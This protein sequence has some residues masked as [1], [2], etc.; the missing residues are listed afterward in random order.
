MTEISAALRPDAAARPFR[1]GYR[2]EIEGLR[3]IAIL[4]VVLAHAKVPGFDGGFV[5]VDVFFVLSGYLITSLLLDELN[6]SGDL[7]I[8]SFYAR[9][10]KR[11]LPALLLVL[12]CGSALA[13][14]LLAPFEQVEQSLPVAAAAVWLS[15]QLFSQAKLDYF[16]SDADSSLFLHTWSLGVEEQFYLAWPALVMFLL[17]AWHW[18]G[19]GF[20]LRRLRGGLLATATVTWVLSVFLTYTQP[21]SAFYLAPSR[22]WQFALGALV[23]LYTQQSAFAIPRALRLMAGWAGLLLVLGAAFTLDAETAYPGFAALAPT[24][25][26]ALILLFARPTDPR[27]VHQ[28]LSTRPMEAIGRVSYAWY[29]WHWPILLLGA[30]VVGSSLGANLGLALL[31]LVLA[32]LTY[33]LIETP[34]RR[35]HSRLAR[36]AIVIT[37]S[38]VL[39]AAAV[40]AA[41]SWNTAARGWAESP[42]HERYSAVRMD[43]PKL[44]A[45]R[46]DDWFHSANV[47]ICQFGNEKAEKRLL[48]I[49]DS[50]GLQWFPAITRIYERKGWQI[51]VLTKSSC[52]MVDQAYF[53]SR[54]GREYVEYTQWRNQVLQLVPD[55]HADTVILGSSYNYPFSHDE[56]VAGTRRILDRIGP[57]TAQVFLLQST[58]PLGINGPDCLSRR[59]WRAERGLGLPLPAC[60]TEVRNARLDTARESLVA[61]AAPYA[62]AHVIDMSEY[63]CPEGRCAADRDGMIVFRDR[64]HVTATYITQLTD[65]LERALNA[66]EQESSP[67]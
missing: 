48:I 28:L 66:A 9:R 4:L 49:G 52:P 46:C 23:L 41:L 64:V 38:V 10:L 67:R 25:G 29:L 60:A 20:N 13:A 8:A 61:A 17:G 27:S 3:A 58:P 45:Y 63:I 44:Y 65:E 15:N 33:W 54:I 2:P 43:V 56:W 11:L 57:A 39:M 12:L 14:L 30:T 34:I 53:Y 5:G 51:L 31:A 7:N 18:Q 6:T 37:V 36:P 22:A 62:N 32:A 21:A 26:T 1:L 59:H 55:L 42:S 19:G 40:C 50:I 47:N 35:L 16:G 24:V